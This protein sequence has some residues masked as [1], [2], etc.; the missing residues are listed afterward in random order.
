MRIPA[1]KG[2]ALQRAIGVDSA[3]LI[4]IVKKNT[5]P[6]IFFAFNLDDVRIHRCQTAPDVVPG[7]FTLADRVQVFDGY[8]AF[9][10]QLSV[11]LMKTGASLLAAATA[12]GAL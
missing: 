2:T 4:F 10:N 8:N 6:T 1:F 3:C 12:S 11:F 5:N 9:F 7:N